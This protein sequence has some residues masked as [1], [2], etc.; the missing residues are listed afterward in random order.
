MASP[1]HFN[2]PYDAKVSLMGH[3]TR[4]IMRAI[5]PKIIGLTFL[6]LEDAA[7]SSD[8]QARCAEIFRNKHKDASRKPFKALIFAIGVLC[9]EIMFPRFQTLAI[10]PSKLL[11][12]TCFTTDVCS[13]LMWA[14]YADQHQGFCIEY[15]TRG[16]TMD[17]LRARWL[18]PVVYSRRRFR[19][20]SMFFMTHRGTAMIHWPT[21][22]AIHKGPEWS[23]EQEWRIVNPTGTEA[24]VEI[25][26]PCSSGIYMGSRISS[27]NEHRIRGIRD[28]IA[29]EK[30]VD[31]P[32]YRMRLSES[33][34]D[35]EPQRID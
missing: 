4:K 20:I 25:L 5:W 11:K 24:P 13:N 31:V 19:M 3:L 30:G 7:N 22:A 10:V 1:D 12:V 6:E 29:S 8:F 17:D 32:L 33:S 9:H 16:L 14:H 28:R 35:L 26:M 34:Y 15:P 27:D 21:L 23:Y 18:Y 2:D